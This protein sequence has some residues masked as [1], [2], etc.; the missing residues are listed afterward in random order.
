MSSTTSCDLH[1]VHFL[2]GKMKM[3]AE[4]TEQTQQLTHVKDLEEG[5]PH[6]RTQ[7]TLAMMMKYVFTIYSLAY[8]GKLI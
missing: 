6:F 2:V 5:L 8:D 4:P 1:W 7:Y 3:M